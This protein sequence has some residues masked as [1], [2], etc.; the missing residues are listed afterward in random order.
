MPARRG[1]AFRWFSRDVCH[2]V[3]KSHSRKINRLFT[4][5]GS[6]LAEV[7]LVASGSACT[8]NL[9]INGNHYP[10]IMTLTDYYP[11]EM[12]SCSAV[13]PT[14][15]YSDG[16]NLSPNYTNARTESGSYWSS[17]SAGCSIGF[18]GT[19]LNNHL[20]G[21][22]DQDVAQFGL[23]VMNYT[24]SGNQGSSGGWMIPLKVQTYC[25]TTLNNPNSTVIAWSGGLQDSGYSCTATTQL[26]GVE[27]QLLCT[28]LDGTQYVLKWNEGSSA[29][30][31]VQVIQP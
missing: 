13:L 25:D 3:D 1:S 22:R 24:D 26:D 8:N 21:Y 2:N 31:A 19:G 6:P 17:S 30:L 11:N 23:R 12:K 18:I 15:V 28:I 14:V 7:L 16:T 20:P 29:Q 4:D 9:K 27:T 5:F 10:W